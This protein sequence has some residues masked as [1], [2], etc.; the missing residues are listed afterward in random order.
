MDALRAT[1]LCVRG[2]TSLKIGHALLGLKK[3][4][5]EALVKRVYSH[6]QVSSASGEGG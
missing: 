4:K 3:G 2:M 1:I 5:R 6:E